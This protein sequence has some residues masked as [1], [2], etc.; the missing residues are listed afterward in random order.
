MTND[1]PSTGSRAKMT[2]RVYTVTREGIVTPPRAMVAVPHDFEPAMEHLNT[3]LGPCRCPL[4]R[5]GGTR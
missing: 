2:I 1:R 5:T 3:D 4:H